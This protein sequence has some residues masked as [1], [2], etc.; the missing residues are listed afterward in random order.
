[1]LRNQT[2]TRTIQ[3][4]ERALS[5][6][7]LFTDESMELPLGEISRR[8]N[9]NISTTQG[10]I[11]SLLHKD[12]LAKNNNN[13]KYLLGHSML[14]HVDPQKSIVEV[15]LIRHISF[16]M[17]QLAADYAAVVL[18]FKNQGT[19]LKNLK[20]VSPY[21]YEFV[22]I[23]D[24]N[25]SVSARVIMTKWTKK[26]IHDYFANKP[27]VRYNEN[28]ITNLTALSQAIRQTKKQGYAIENEEICSGLSAIAVPIYDPGGNIAATISVN[29]RTA[30]IKENRQA[31]CDRLFQISYNMTKAVNWVV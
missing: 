3:S 17:H 2:V 29:S 24:F 23:M 20:I 25:C 8:L 5:I 4:V 28:T 14:N 9:L 16:H 11:N 15:D 18:L 22:P 6:L 21:P 1:M 31:I 19:T 26:Q 27:L 10:L 30:L 13:G 7:D 12:Y